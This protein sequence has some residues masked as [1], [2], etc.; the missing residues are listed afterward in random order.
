LE[1]NA[2]ESEFEVEAEAEIEADD[3]ISEMDIDADFYVVGVAAPLIYCIVS[4][5]CPRQNTR[6]CQGGHYSQRPPNE[7]VPPPAFKTKTEIC[8]SL[9][10][11]PGK[12]SKQSKASPRLSHEQVA[13]NIGTRRT[14]EDT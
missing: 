13:M 14:S 2:G 10:Q 5:S 6:L 11:R 9:Q 7:R 8:T 12:S 4:T 3:D 1:S